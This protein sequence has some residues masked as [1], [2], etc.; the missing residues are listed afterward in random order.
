MLFENGQYYLR[1]VGAHR[2]LVKLIDVDPFGVL[3]N[4]RPYH[5]DWKYNVLVGTPFGP[6]DFHT[7]SFIPLYSLRPMWY[8]TEPY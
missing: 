4:N 8:E 2:S 1:I 6:N 5:I 7:T 3:D